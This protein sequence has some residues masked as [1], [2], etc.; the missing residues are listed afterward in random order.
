[1]AEAV[2]AL[3]PTQ[4]PS[5]SE[6]ADIQEAFRLYHYG[7]PAGTG[8]GEYDPT[9]TDPSALNP[10][11]TTPSIAFYLSDLQG[12]ITSISGTLGVQATTWSAKG[13]LVTATAASTVSALTVGTN[14]QVLTANSATATGLQWSSPQVTLSN[15]ATLTNKNISLGTNSITGTLAQFNTALTDADFISDSST[16][17]LTNKTVDLASNTL[18]GTL[19]QFNT[20][21]SDGTFVTTDATQTLTNKTI[22]GSQIS[23]DISGNAANVT[24]TVAIANGGTGATTA[25]TAKSNLQIFNNGSSSYGGTIFV[26][27][28]EPSSASAGD[29]WMY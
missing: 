11:G 27:E 19:S 10:T 24:G 7:R 2:G 26:Q 29:I 23:G 22:G 17:T 8:T 21:L 6:A 5:L 20:A 13:A 14:G 28:T 4:I 3:F 9:N 1:M 18:T 12:Q 15:A 25:T 16:T